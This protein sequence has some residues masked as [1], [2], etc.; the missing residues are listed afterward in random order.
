MTEDFKPYDYSPL[1]VS[2][3]LYCESPRHGQTHVKAAFVEIFSV[4]PDGP[5]RLPNGDSVWRLL[6]CQDCHADTL[7][8]YLD[9]LLPDISDPELEAL[10][11]SDPLAYDAYLRGEFDASDGDNPL[12]SEAIIQKRRKLSRNKKGCR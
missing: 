1:P 10:K 9:E 6:S 12:P 2:R 4:D 3:H 11:E 7:R 5:D 8:A